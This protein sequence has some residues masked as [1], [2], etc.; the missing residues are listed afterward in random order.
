M[1]YDKIIFHIYI[2]SE[3]FGKIPTEVTVLSLIIV[4]PPK[5]QKKISTTSNNCCPQIKVAL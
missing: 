3:N 2:F 1:V 4:A 5:F